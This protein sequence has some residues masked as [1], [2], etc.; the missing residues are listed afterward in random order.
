MPRSRTELGSLLAPLAVYLLTILFVQPWGDYPLNDDWIYARIGKR[1]AETGRFVFDHDTGSAF[2]GQGLIAAPVIRLLGFSHTHLR[3]LTMLFGALTICLLWL[4][5]R[6]AAVR[7]GIRVVCLLAV[8]WN[9]LFSYL[10]LT[11]MTEIY[12]YCFA[13]LGAAIWMRD[14]RAHPEGPLVSWLG[15]ALAAAAIAAGFWIRQY[16]VLVF[17]ALLLSSIAA[18]WPRVRRS[19]PRLALSGMIFTAVVVA[20]FVF[21]RTMAE[22][23][24]ADYS[25]RLGRIWPVNIGATFLQAG[26]FLAYMTAFLLPLLAAAKLQWERRMAPAAIALALVG[27]GCGLVLLQTPPHLDLHPQFPFLGNV[28]RN[29]GIGPILLPDVQFLQ[30]R[31]PAWPAAAWGTLELILLAAGLLWVPLMFA[32]PRII[33]KGGLRAELLLFSLLFAAASLTVTTFVDRL[34]AFD[35]YYLPETFALTLALG[36]ILSEAPRI[37][38]VRYAVALLPL[39]FFTVAG[40]HDYFRWNDAAWD[41]YR[42][43]LRSGVSPT[44]I[45]ASYEMNGWNAFSQFKDAGFPKTQCDSEWFCL[46]NA[47]RIGMNVYGNYEPV[48]QR[49]P[50]YWLAPGPPLILSKRK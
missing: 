4:L 34:A 21:A 24:M 11:F 5:L 10:S 17:P 9:P 13:L 29:A 36:L 31:S 40:L 43:A 22:V 38:I 6:Y 28:I 23:P 37:S 47:Y 3:S 42:Q 33:R 20:Y 30:M 32:A 16:S 41:L 25:R 12:A 26:I 8:V 19:L 48:A 50:R 7:P 1:F 45:E 35:R 46:D 49:Q 27:A 14:R 18:G 2:I 15:A 39:A 44:S